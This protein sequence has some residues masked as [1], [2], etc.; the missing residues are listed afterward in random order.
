MEN[1]I[2]LPSRLHIALPSRVFKNVGNLT[3]MMILPAGK[4][5]LRD[6]ERF[7][8]PLQW[9]DHGGWLHVRAVCRSVFALCG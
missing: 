4:Y 8:I 7:G 1:R 2:V 3:N 9:R 5:T 6:F